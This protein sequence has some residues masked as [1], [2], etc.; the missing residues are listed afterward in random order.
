M[1]YLVCALIL[2]LGLSIGIAVGILIGTT[3]MQRA[4]EEGSIGDLRID[5]SE[6]DEP[7]KPYLEVY[8]GNT[9][10]SI[11]KKKFVMLR[12]I[13]ESYISRD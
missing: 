12:I 7:P 10:E 5:R 2:V 1:E 13:D 6:P 9:I 3:R 8:T 4:V 11:A